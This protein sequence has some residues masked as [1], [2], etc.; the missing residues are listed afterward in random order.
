MTDSPYMTLGISQKAAYSKLL[1]SK[2]DLNGHALLERL[3]YGAFVPKGP[4]KPCGQ[5]Y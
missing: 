5:F 2:D 1:T 3:R 4:Y